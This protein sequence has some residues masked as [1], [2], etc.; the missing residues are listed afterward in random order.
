M[1]RIEYPVSAAEPFLNDHR[2]GGLPL[3][4]T[5]MG[6][7]FMARAVRQVRGAA[8]GGPVYINNARVLDPLILKGDAATVSVVVDSQ[9]CAMQGWQAG[10]SWVLMFD[11]QFQEVAPVVAPQ[12]L[13]A[14]RIDAFLESRVPGHAVYELFFHGPAFRVVGSAAFGAGA[15]FSELAADLPSLTLDST[16]VLTAAPHW[17]ELCMQTAGLLEIAAHARMMIPH[18]IDR[19]HISPVQILRPPLFA[20]A[21]ERAGAGVDVTLSDSAGAVCVQ[22]TGYRTLPLPFAADTAAIKTLHERFSARG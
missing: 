6:F 2:P 1:T 12:S 22:M 16:Q 5:A 14:A 10:E 15:L 17:I 3:L 9:S 21:Q 8:A 11:A 20:C 19:L 4:G 13:S 7:E 18:R